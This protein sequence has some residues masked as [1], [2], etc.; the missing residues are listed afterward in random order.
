[1]EKQK[2]LKGSLLRAVVCDEEHE[3]R[4]DALKAWM[5]A[6]FAKYRPHAEV[7]SLV[8]DG[9]ETVATAEVSG[10]FLGSRAAPLQVHA[11]EDKIVALAIGT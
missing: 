5:D 7:T 9:E 11:G 1:M 6:A 8:P 10:V 3:D 2:S 4:G